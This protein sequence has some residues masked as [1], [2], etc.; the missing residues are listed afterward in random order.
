M[1]PIIDRRYRPVTGKDRNGHLSGAYRFAAVGTI[2]CVFA[3]QHHHRVCL[4]AL[5]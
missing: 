4:F 5:S 2:S 1:L 3:M